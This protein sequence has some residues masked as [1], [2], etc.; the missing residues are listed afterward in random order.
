MLQKEKG[1]SAFVAIV[2]CVLA[3]SAVGGLL[4][5]LGCENPPIEG[6]GVLVIVNWTAQNAGGAAGSKLRTIQS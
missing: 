3:G 5:R 2:L 4:C 6:R 1:A